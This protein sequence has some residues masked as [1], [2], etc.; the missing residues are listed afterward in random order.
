[1][2]FL[3]PTQKDPRSALSLIDIYVSFQTGP[4]GFGL[5]LLEAMAM[6][7]PLIISYEKGGLEDL[8]H[9]GQEGFLFKSTSLE[10]FSEKILELLRS[11]NMRQ[12]MGQKAAEK[13]KT[14]FS[15]QRMTK[16]TIKVYESLR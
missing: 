11:P 6:G 12:Q 13:A 15:Y 2:I 9:N 14:F 10:F 5:S 8:I 1:M 7:K 4:E 3:L 16:E